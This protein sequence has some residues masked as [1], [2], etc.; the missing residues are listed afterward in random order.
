[1]SKYDSYPVPAIRELLEERCLEGVPTVPLLELLKHVQPGRYQVKS[2]AYDP[3]APTPVLSP[4]KGFLLGYTNET[5]GIFDASSSNPTIIFDD[6]TTNFHWVD[7]PFKVKSSAMKMLLPQTD[8]VNLR[9]V[10]WVMQTIP[11]QP[12]QHQ[13]QWIQTYSHFEVPLPHPDVQEQIVAILD[14]FTDYTTNLRREL[15]LRLQQLEYYRDQL[16]TFPVAE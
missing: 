15:D 5:D 16:L 3:S 9:Y 2:A 14:M 7:F 11:Y 1:M 6:F 4:G 12:T 10:Y 8:D 13:R